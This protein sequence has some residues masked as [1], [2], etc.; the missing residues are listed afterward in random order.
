MGINSN[1]PQPNIPGKAGFPVETSKTTPET[2]KKTSQENPINLTD[3]AKA[4]ATTQPKHRASIALP[5]RDNSRDSGSLEEM[6]SHG[7]Q[8]I[9]QEK[10][11]ISQPIATNATREAEPYLSKTDLLPWMN[12]IAKAGELGTNHILQQFT[13]HLEKNNRITPEQKTLLAG[14]AAN[15]IKEDLKGMEAAK[16]KVMSSPLWSGDLSVPLKSEKEEVAQ[17]KDSSRS[18]QKAV[19]ENMKGSCDH[20]LEIVKS[21]DLN[22]KGKKELTDFLLETKKRVPDIEG[23]ARYEI[24]HQGSEWD[25]DV[26]IHGEIHFNDEFTAESTM[27]AAGPGYSSQAPRHRSLDLPDNQIVPPN[28]FVSS[29]KINGKEVM[30]AT[31]SAITVEFDQSN[32]DIRTAMNRKELKKVLDVQTANQLKKKGWEELQKGTDPNHPITVK[33]MTVNLLTP[34]RLRQMTRE[35]QG[36]AQQTVK[37]NHALSGAPSD[38]ERSLAE[39][40]LASHRFWNNQVEEYTIKNENGEEVKIYVQYDLKYFNV[41]NNVLNEKLPE[42]LT[43]SKELQQSNNESFNKLKGDVGKQVEALNAA[44]SKEKPNLS[45]IEKAQ[46]RELE[47]LRE[48]KK[49]LR[50]EVGKFS[51]KEQSVAATE[52]FAAWQDVADRLAKQQKKLQ[53]DPNL[54]PAMRQT[55][56]AFDTKERLA[57]LYN[58]TQELY[59]GGLSRDLNNMDNNRSALATRFIALGSLIEE[60][61]VHFGCRSGKDRTGLVD[62]EVKVLFTLAEQLGRMPSYREEERNALTHGIREKV[63]LES[64]NVKGIVT[65]TLG[66]TLGLN[67]GGSASK[68]REDSTEAEQAQHNEL[69]D[70]TRAYAGMASRPTTNLPITPAYVDKFSSTREIHISTQTPENIIEMKLQTSELRPKETPQELQALAKQALQAVTVH[71]ANC[72]EFNQVVDALKSDPDWKNIIKSEL[73][74]LSPEA[75]SALI[76][77]TPYDLRSYDR[78]FLSELF[79]AAQ[80]RGAPAQPESEHLQALND[81]FKTKILYLNEKSDMKYLGGGVLNTVYQVTYTDPE[82]GEKK[83][84]VFKPETS[85]L[86]AAKLLKEQQFGTSVASG[87]P[88][89]VN[90]HLSSRAVASSA[91]DG[92]LNK[93]DRI[94]VKTEFVIINGQRGILMEKAAGGVPKLVGEVQQEILPAEREQIRKL[95]A[96][97]RERN[98][99]PEQGF[100]LLASSINYRK[101]E[102]VGDK[103]IGTRAKFERF[104]PQ[105]PTTIGGLIDLQIKDIIAGECDRHS[106]NYHIDSDGKVTGID[107]DCC[108]GVNALPQEGDVRGQESLWGIVP[109]RGSLMLRMPPVITE[110]M[111]AK[112]ENQYQN[113]ST[114]VKEL[115]PYVSSAEIDATLQRLEKLHAH[116]NN[117]NT[118]MIAKNNAELL[119][120]KAQQLMD[121][122]NSYYKREVQLLFSQEKDLGA[123]KDLNLPPVVEEFIKDTFIPNKNFNIYREQ[124]NF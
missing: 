76:K 80:E 72:R 59:L 32:K 30:Q 85:E 8:S 34:D 124:R 77:A 1:L 33:C 40:N 54:S 104:D 120:A 101:L 42:F 41:P 7:L 89:G 5:P 96:Q 48:T 2:T 13:S 113:K 105:N 58:D 66:A 114:L 62:I 75:F 45:D 52:K 98:I 17:Y 86:G 39:E 117:P 109:N 91:I 73:N 84:G 87:I 79:T 53:N 108:L 15:Q 23:R 61:E 22:A 69:M 18:L 74:K 112:I 70:T 65:A 35:N 20:L 106:Q 118:C 81:F 60:N 36:L 71:K 103:L 116:I 19:Q 16:D 64:G 31:R 110:A 95:G 123:I 25:P 111:K 27:K 122:N 67:T 37:I 44:I 10:A 93:D 4:S 3:L 99:P 14:L 49:T 92:L 63:T 29:Y 12:N 9:R 102:F 50:N 38:D 56:A 51:V 55:L 47:I 26:G 115:S 121:T 28:F 90:A 43:F 94:S 83:V 82:T 24:I 11:G 88:S 100:Q 78:E 97:L 107:E 46:L 119:S 21:S 6:A 68:P 57:D